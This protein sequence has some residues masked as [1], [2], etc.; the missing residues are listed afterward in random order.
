[1][2]WMLKME[3]QNPPD[4]RAA[5]QQQ[6]QAAKAITEEKVKLCLRL[7]VWAPADRNCRAAPFGSV[8]A[9]YA[10][11]KARGLPESVS[12]AFPF[13]RGFHEAGGPQLGCGRQDSRTLFVFGCCTHCFSLTGACK[14]SC[15][16]LS[17]LFAPGF[18]STESAIHRG[19]RAAGPSPPI[20]P[21]RADRI[22]VAKGS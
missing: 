14:I 6:L 8:S 10:P 7:E 2:I 20:R 16:R 21:G 1:M 12:S 5:E 9:T 4:Q 22:A 13:R 11:Y 18:F 17:F 19:A 15:L 3:N